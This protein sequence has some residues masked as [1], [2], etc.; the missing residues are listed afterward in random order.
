MND[1]IGARLTNGEM[2][3]LVEYAQQVN[4][5]TDA[6]VTSIED[7]TLGVRYLKM[8]GQEHVIIGDTFRPLEHVNVRDRTILV[9]TM[10]YGSC[11]L[12]LANLNIEAG[13]HRFFILKQTNELLKLIVTLSPGRVQQLVSQVLIFKEEKLI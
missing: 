3:N 2:Q 7:I 1:I 11:I 5:F 13:C 6:L 10:L 8:Y 12:E 4:I 9:N